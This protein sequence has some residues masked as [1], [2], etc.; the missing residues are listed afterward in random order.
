MCVGGVCLLGGS[1][2]GYGLSKLQRA[3]E[4][5]SLLSLRLKSQEGLAQLTAIS[6]PPEPRPWALLS[7][8][9]SRASLWPGVMDTR[10]GDPTRTP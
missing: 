6:D 8:S 10:P 9:R 3:E 2:W 4:G 1:V 7:G 5:S